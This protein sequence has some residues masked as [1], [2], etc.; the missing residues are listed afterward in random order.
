MLIL[1]GVAINLTI[2][3]NGIFKKSSEG[4]EIYKNSANAEA[5]S[6][7]E[8]DELLGNMIKDTKRQ[9]ITNKGTI[10]CSITWENKKAS[11]SLGTTSEYKVQYQVNG[12]KEESWIEGTQVNELN[13]NDIVY[14]RLYD[15]E[16]A[17]NSI[18]I[19]IEDTQQPNEAN[20]SVSATTIAVEN[21]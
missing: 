11:M 17:G 15:G 8:V 6:L 18:K 1:A 20:I 5:S 9:E 4:A 2:G 21:Q 14:A 19:V 7:N 3:E 16:L 12:E 10:E 13:L